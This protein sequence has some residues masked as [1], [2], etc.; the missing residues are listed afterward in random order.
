MLE[1]ASGDSAIF[2]K[3][4]APLKEHAV[5]KHEVSAGVG[6]IY[7]GVGKVGRAVEAQTQKPSEIGTY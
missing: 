4:K 2:A 1:N 3:Y 7:R 5:P 6:T